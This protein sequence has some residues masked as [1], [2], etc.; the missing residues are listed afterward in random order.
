MPIHTNLTRRIALPLLAGLSLTAA[1]PDLTVTKVLVGQA[2]QRPDGSLRLAQDKRGF[3]RIFLQAD[4]A[5]TSL[6]AVRARFYLNGTQVHEVT[7]PAPAGLT[8]VPMSV[9]EGEFAKTWL[10]TVPSNVYKPGLSVQVEIDPTLSVPDANRANN[11]WPA[12]GT[13]SVTVV[14]TRPFRITFVP[15][16]VRSRGKTFLGRIDATSAPRFLDMLQRIWPMPDS[17]D[18]A[19]HAP[20]TPSTVPD[21]N[22]RYPTWE[23]V[24]NELG[25]MQKAEGKTNRYY[26]GVYNS[27]YGTNGGTGMA[28]LGKPQAM[29]I[30]WDLL[31]SPSTFT[32]RAGTVA[33]EVG[34]SL[35]RNHAPCG[36]AGS[37]DPNYPYAGAALGTWGYDVWA[38][39]IYDPAKTFDVM[40]YC[41]FNWVSDYNVNK[42][43]DFRLSGDTTVSG[44]A[45]GVKGQPCTLVW[46]TVENGE[47]MLQPAFTI[48]ADPD[49]PADEGSYQLDLLSERGEV[50]GTTTFEPERAA[51]GAGAGFALAVP[52][53]AMKKGAKVGSLRVTRN[54]QAMAR[55]LGAQDDAPHKLAATRLNQEEVQLVWD[56]AKYPMVMVK[57]S[58][59]QV[60]G[61]GRDGELVLLTPGDSLEVHLSSGSRSHAVPVKIR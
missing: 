48:Q 53:H 5:N 20:Y 58:M 14:D 27:Y 30:D 25:A 51:H 31:S 38:G 56:A 59:G 55:R 17:I 61:C 18:W 8:G 23:T 24:L 45:T 9:T 42:V 12:T 35:N 50:I 40:A 41:N 37:P 47:V 22:Y 54:G 1:T 29:G 60:I 39:K 26:Y 34:H 4:V 57:N 16:S 7:I 3:V 6:P 13:Q 32:W 11:L 43:T 52:N 21:A 19:I 33:H 10:A 36:G 44:T 2:T 49:M 46:G 15:L 28:W